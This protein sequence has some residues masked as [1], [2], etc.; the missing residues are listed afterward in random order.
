MR[1]GRRRPTRYVFVPG[2]VTLPGAGRVRGLRRR[3]R[4]TRSVGSAVRGKS[5]SIQVTVRPPRSDP[6]VPVL[7]VRLAS[8]LARAAGPDDLSLLEDEVA[9]GDAR[10]RVDVLVD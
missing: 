7:D 10:E 3:T 8:Q 5:G 4:A 6:E 2:A 9:V 1:I